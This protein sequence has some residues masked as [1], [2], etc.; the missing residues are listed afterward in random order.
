[1]SFRED[2]A[3]AVE[4]VA[5][6]LERLRDF[7]VLAQVEPGELRSRLPASPPEAPEPFAAVLR[8]L[9]EL[10]LPG[11]THW[12]SP[13]FFAYFANT[14][15]E[16]G[17]LAELLAAGLNQVGILWRTSPAL[18]ELEELALDWLAQLLGLPDGLHGHIED[19]ASTCTMAALA[20]ARHAK[21]GARAVVVSEHAHSSVAKACRL[22]ELE[23]RTVPV[24]EAFGL[25]PDALD[26]TGA[27]AVVATVGTTST[28]SVDPVAAIAAR[29]EAAGAWLHVDAAYAG[30][31]AVCPELRHHFAG[32]ERADS[33]VVNPH[34]WLLTPMDCSTM[35][36]RRPDD[37]RAAFSLVPEYLRVS[38]EVAS[39]SEYSPVLG[40]RFRALK[41]WAV[42]R[43][44]GRTGL[45]ERIREAVRLAA[46]F[47]EWVREEAGW[48]VTAPRPFSLVCFRHEGSDAE[49]EALLERVNA[50][51]E[52]FLSHTKLDGRYSL[53]LAVGNARTTE[54]DVRLAWDVLRREAARR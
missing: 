8:D 53:R 27:C 7:P 26:L 5:S 40:R 48:E 34:K 42:L 37:L 51:G 52:V 4:W 3:A 38:E 25:R 13:R 22:L 41:L 15:S 23:L 31:A 9:D 28:S 11:I 14:G 35:W 24:D 6:Y 50:S 36:T 46:L 2:G 33:V 54:D 44:Y 39:L 20:A 29:A 45:Q 21:P 10:L 30:S 32:W 49:N 19:T 43:C 1:M 18:Q 16:P 17:V 12:Q 47:E